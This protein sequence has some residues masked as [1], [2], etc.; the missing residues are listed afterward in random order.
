S[1]IMSESPRRFK[2]RA[3]QGSGSGFGGDGVGSDRAG[4]GG[5]SRGALVPGWLVGLEDST[6]PTPLPPVRNPGVR[7][8]RIESS[9]HL[10]RALS[11]AITDLGT[12]VHRIKELD[13]LRGIAAFAVIVYHIQF[14]WLPIG[15][16]AVDLFFVLSGYLITGIIIRDGDTPH[17]LGTFY[18]RRGLR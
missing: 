13:G 1:D 5:R 8:P 15:W 18:V 17:F 6:H 10:C 12:R 2:G 14:D 16:A 4:A 3:N 11:T 9:W 7:R